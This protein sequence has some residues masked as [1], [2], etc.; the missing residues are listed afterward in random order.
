M[1]ELS[2]SLRMTCPLRLKVSM[3]PSRPDKARRRTSGTSSTTGSRSNRITSLTHIFRSISNITT[4]TVMTH[5]TPAAAMRWRSRVVTERVIPLCL[6]PCP[7]STLVSFSITLSEGKKYLAI[8]GL[9]SCLHSSSPRCP[10]FFFTTT[11]PFRS[12]TPTFGFIALPHPSPAGLSL[13]FAYRRFP[14]QSLPLPP[15][16]TVVIAL[17][18][19]PLV[20]GS[21][22]LFFLSPLYLSL[23]DSASNRMSF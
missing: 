3:G 6:P 1:C 23:L 22:V 18:R 17:A 5:P 11:P 13:L 7:S 10:L 8:F 14:S 16:S 15:P 9:A 19:S 21:I 4:I 20:F 2:F 12:L